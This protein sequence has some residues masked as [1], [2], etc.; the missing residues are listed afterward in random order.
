MSIPLKVFLTTVRWP[1]LQVPVPLDRPAV[2][3]MIGEANRIWRAYGITFRVASCQSVTI[4]MPRTS[5]ACITDDS[6]LFLKR[7]LDDQDRNSVKVALSGQTAGNLRD[8]RTTIDGRFL[9]VSAGPQ[10]TIP[11]QANVLA[12]EMGHVFGLEDL[13]WVGDARTPPEERLAMRN[14]LMASLRSDQRTLLTEDQLD[15]VGRSS[16][17][18]HWVAQR[19][20]LLRRS[21]ERMGRHPITP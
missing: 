14:N 3:R 15:T 20:Q 19:D 16:L 10:M 7:Q 12:H 13:H 2:D 11:A 9:L 21:R 1:S 18:A 5:R 4:D 8:G 17:V 6:F